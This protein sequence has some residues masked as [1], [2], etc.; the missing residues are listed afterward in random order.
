MYINSIAKNNDKKND[1]I[2]LDIEGVFYTKIMLIYDWS[3][4][5]STILTTIQGG[6]VEVLRV[7][8]GT[9]AGSS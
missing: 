9:S 4:V 6:V 2:I 3:N 1:V 7:A 8:S 5:Q